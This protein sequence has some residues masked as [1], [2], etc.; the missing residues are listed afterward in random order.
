LIGWWP[1]T[2]FNNTFSYATKIAWAGSVL[3][4]KN[5]MSPPMGSGHMAAEGAN[6]AAY[7]SHIK[8]YDQFGGVVDPDESAVKELTDK[9]D[10]FRT[11]GFKYSHG[12]HYNFYYG[13]PAGC[14][15]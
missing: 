4:P 3:Y 6:K 13:G 10:C 14:R 7:I 5:E 2:L 1:K 8:L 9:Y 11:D 12:K 15:N